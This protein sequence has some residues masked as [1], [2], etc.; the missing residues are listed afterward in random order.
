MTLLLA[1]LHA[2]ADGDLDQDLHVPLPC[3]Q[4]EDRKCLQRRL[5]CLAA[6][7]RPSASPA[8]M[9]VV[10]SAHTVW[11]EQIAGSSSISIWRIDRTTVRLLA[12]PSTNG[13]HVAYEDGRLSELSCGEK[14]TSL[15]VEAGASKSSGIV[16]MTRTALRV[17]EAEAAHRPRCDL[18]VAPSCA[19]ERRSARL[20]HLVSHDLDPPHDGGV[21]FDRSRNIELKH[22]KSQREA[23]R[24]RK[25]EQPVAPAVWILVLSIPQ[26][27]DSSRC[28][29]KKTGAMSSS[30]SEGQKVYVCDAKY[31]STLT[32]GELGSRRRSRAPS[33]RRPRGRR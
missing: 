24:P 26:L 2:T 18:P 1:Q 27:C 22:G 12:Q 20:R 33:G 4:T 29:E 30:V 7:R 23:R 31:R 9:W 8:A 13:F 28:C 6:R 16:R 5:R 14:R 21:P 3:L 10:A 15:S 19:P 11:F 32:R 17:L 25:P